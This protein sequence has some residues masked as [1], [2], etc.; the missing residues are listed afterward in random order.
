MDRTAYVLNRKYIQYIVSK[1]VKRYTMTNIKYNLDNRHVLSTS[2]EILANTF[3]ENRGT[4][5]QST[6]RVITYSIAESH[7]WSE[8]VGVE[9]GVEFSI[10]TSVPLVASKSVSHA[11]FALLSNTIKVEIKHYSYH[12]LATLSVFNYVIEP[13]R[14]LKVG[15]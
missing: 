9:V 1:P 8:T 10:T 3:L 12:V 15:L 11:Q 2:P 13:P 7:S 14:M 5:P 4:I 6:T